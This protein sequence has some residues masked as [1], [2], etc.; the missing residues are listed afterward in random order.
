M[1]VQPTQAGMQNLGT[2]KTDAQGKFS[3]DSNDAQGPRLIRAMYEGVVYNKM[4]PPGM[5]STGVQ[6]DVYD[7]TNKPGT[8]KVTQHFI[9]LQP[10]TSETTVSEGLL[11]Q[12]DPNLDLQRPRKARSASI[13]RPR[14]RAR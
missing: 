6:V 14:P 1:L 2:T 7:S 9:V 11:Y 8:A 4:I 13:F 10:G 5:P 3:F 12:G